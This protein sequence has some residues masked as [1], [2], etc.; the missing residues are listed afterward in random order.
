M[1]LRGFRS[2][3]I[4]CPL[5]K[6]GLVGSVPYLVIKVTVLRFLSYFLLPL[7][8]LIL[9]MLSLLFRSLS[10]SS[11]SS[12]SSSFS[13]LLLLLLLLI[14][15]LLLLL[16]L[17]RWFSFFSLFFV[18]FLSSFSFSLCL[19]LFFSSIIVFLLDPYLA[20]QSKT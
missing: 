18:F 6:I 16:L 7:P 20:A 13:L 2:V 5:E 9:P 17:L 12:S 3:L 10:L 19:S 1:S 8:F 14:L 15:L 4:E 11:S